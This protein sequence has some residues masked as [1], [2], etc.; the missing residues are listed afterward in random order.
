MAKNFLNQMAK[1]FIVAHKVSRYLIA[2]FEIA[3][4]KEDNFWLVDHDLAILG[5]MISQ[6]PMYVKVFVA[7]EESVVLISNWDLKSDSETLDYA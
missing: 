7:C 6:D 3:S 4:A 1:N 2:G 5:V